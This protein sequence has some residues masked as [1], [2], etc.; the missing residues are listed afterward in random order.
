MVNV[1]GRKEEENENFIMPW[2]LTSTEDQPS[3]VTVTS[4]GYSI[5]KAGE[6]ELFKRGLLET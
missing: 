1:T 3:L 5:T 6:V 4:K 2:L